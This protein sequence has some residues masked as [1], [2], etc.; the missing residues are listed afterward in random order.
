VFPTLYRRVGVIGVALTAC[1]APAR[2]TPITDLGRAADLIAFATVDGVVETGDQAAPAV[3]F[4]L[5]LIQIIKGESSSLNVLAGFAARSDRGCGGGGGRTPCLSLPPDMVGKTGIWFL[6]SGDRGYQIVPRQL[7]S[8]FIRSDDLYLPMTGPPGR[9]VAIG[10]LDDVLLAYEVRWFQ[11]LADPDYRLV[12]EELISSFEH[13]NSESPT[14]QQALAAIAPLI[15]SP[16]AW[17]H[18]AGLMV[19]LRI[20]SADA[21]SMVVNELSAL[22]SDPRF[23]EIVFAIGAYPIAGKKDAR[24][25]APLRRLLALHADV[26]GLDAAAAGA[27]YRIGTKDTLPMIAEL[28]ESKDQTA[29]TIAVKTLG[30][31][32]G[33]GAFGPLAT[34]QTLRFTPGMQRPPLTTSE[35][36]DFWKAWWSRNRANLGFPVR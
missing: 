25:L 4:Q 2:S 31:Y 6:R 15:E 35:Y 13:R 5:R 21:M 19:A 16:V 26:P 10:A 22:R 17:Q 29:Q 7:Q 1:I 34:E 12:D 14:Q 36:V 32:T 30:L 23:P 27:L 8:P 20:D 18:A 33:S 24:W 28:L 11:S 3:I 9:V